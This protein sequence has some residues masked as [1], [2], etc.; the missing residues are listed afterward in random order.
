[1]VYWFHCI[2]Y[3]VRYDREQFNFKGND[4]LI[5]IKCVPCKSEWVQREGTTQ[6]HFF[7]PYGYILAGKSGP[8]LVFF[9]FFGEA[10]AGEVSCI[11]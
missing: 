7:S 4:R 5:M 10:T 8:V 6:L 2:W 11:G 1:M 3:L 9:F